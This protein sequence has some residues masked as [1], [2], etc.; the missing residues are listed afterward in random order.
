MLQIGQLRL[1]QMDLLHLLAIQ[2]DSNSTSHNL[3]W[4][5]Q[6][7]EI[8][9]MHGSQRTRARALL[10]LRQAV[11]ATQRLRDDATLNR[12]EKR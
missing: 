8:T 7:G 12:R 9:I 5:D 3:G 4:I 11:F 2:L 1:V 6:V 10:L